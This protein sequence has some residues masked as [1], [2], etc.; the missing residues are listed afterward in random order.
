MENTSHIAK[1]SYEIENWLYQGMDIETIRKKIRKKQSAGSFPSNLELVNAFFDKSNSVSGCAFLDKN[2]GETIVGFAGTNLDNGFLESAKDI[3]TDAS[4]LTDGI[5]PNSSYLKE[6]NN[7]I[8]NL[9]NQGFN[10]TQS[11]GHSLGG[12][13][14]VLVGIKQDIPTVISYNGAP[15]Y[16]LVDGYNLNIVLTIEAISKAYN[17]HI[18]RFV[19][20]DDLLNNAS[21][22]ANGFYIGEKIVFHNDTGHGISNFLSP[23]E[24]SFIK[25]ILESKN[26]HWR[27]GEFEVDFNGDKNA[28][29]SITPE[30]LK[31]KNLLSSD[32]SVSIGTTISINPQTLFE[33][34]TGFNLMV[35][36]DI[37]WIIKSVNICN[38]KNEEIKNNKD[39]RVDNLCD[40]VV[41]AL[42]SLGLNNLLCGINKSHGVLLDDENRSTLEYLS[43][44]DTY[45]ITRKFDWLGDSGG[46]TWYRAG[47]EFDEYDLINWIKDLKSCSYTLL[48]QITATGAIDIPNISGTPS[49][50]LG[51]GVTKKITFTTLSDIGNSLVAITNNFL[52]K[53]TDVFK[54]TGIRSGKQDGIVDSLSDVFKVQLENV[55]EISKGISS[56]GS[57]AIELSNHFKYLDEYMA[58]NFDSSGGKVQ[59]RS[60]KLPENYQAYL[61]ESNIFDDVNVI[62]AFDKQVEEASKKLSIEILKDFDA[63][64]RQTSD[65]F[66]KVSPS[67]ESFNRALKSLNDMLDDTITSKKTYNRLKKNAK[68]DY[69][70]SQPYNF[71][72]GYQPNDY[73]LVTETYQHGTLSSILPI[74]LSN[75]L[76]YASKNIVPILEEFYQVT[77]LAQIYNTNLTYLRDYLKGEVEKSVYASMDLKSIIE[78]Q[79]LISI[80][81]DRIIA[82]IDGVDKQIESQKGKSMK[83]YQSQLGD[84]KKLLEFFNRMIDDC[85]GTNVK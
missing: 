45:E 59:F 30:Q 63:P 83:S 66:K 9:K 52:P 44:F 13:I 19:T 34:S 29:I 69:V 24:Q 78:A 16:V 81:I 31:I 80:T 3:I 17:G 11:T 67:F 72:S 37:S 70:G 38:Q 74:D 85:F 1:I 25:G 56:V 28:K 73:E 42:N 75:Y 14:C 55:N 41:E 33:L 48:Y 68:F 57:M 18:Y 36:N 7:F 22:F 10:I 4:I 49:P 53:T 26:S 2:T 65:Y 50:Y 43:S 77:N 5:S 62:K 47:N 64:L 54:G 20:N 8:S 23:I 71:G 61:K 46:R 82:E 39:L 21:E 76:L 58:N 84:V 35:N 6:A 15:L 12:A 27:N 60:G 79:N 51:Q 32:T 40:K